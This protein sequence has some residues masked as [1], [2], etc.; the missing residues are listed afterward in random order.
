MTLYYV[1]YFQFIWNTRNIKQ[2]TIPARHRFV[3]CGASCVP[4]CSVVPSSLQSH[5]LQPA[6]PLCLW[7]VLILGNLHNS[8]IT[9]ASL[10]P[11]A[12]AGRFFTTGTTQEGFLGGSDGKESAFNVGDPDW[13]TGLG[14]CPG[15]GNGYPLLHSCLENSMDKEACQSSLQ[16]HRV[17]HN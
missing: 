2:K 7:S 17:G 5:G 15:E 16:G 13:I 12:F 3:S 1:F 8:G 9:P 4:L 11:P 10:V 14:R 6:R